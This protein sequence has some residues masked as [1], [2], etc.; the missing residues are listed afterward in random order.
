MADARRAGTE[1]LT[2]AASFASAGLAVSTLVRFIAVCMTRD[3]I[4][5]LRVE[6]RAGACIAR[7]R[8][9]RGARRG[10]LLRTAS[11]CGHAVFVAE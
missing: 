1:A 6:W 5:V 8:C 10:E 9:H 2:E 7:G 3:A 4:D 11:C